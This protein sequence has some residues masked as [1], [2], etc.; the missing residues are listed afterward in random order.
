MSQL[1]AT[2]TFDSDSSEDKEKLDKMNAVFFDESDESGEPDFESAFAALEEK[3]QEV[4]DEQKKGSPAFK[5]LEEVSD[6]ITE[7][8]CD[9]NIEE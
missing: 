3:V 4:L 7:I 9:H 1:T 2:F 5:A 8:K 6:A